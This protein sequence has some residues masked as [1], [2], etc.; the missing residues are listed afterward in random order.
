[1][2]IDS[3]KEAISW[4]TTEQELDR[5]VY[6]YGDLKEEKLGALFLYL[7]QKFSALAL[8]PGGG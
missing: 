3:Y 2:P 7:K 6:A 1:M 4:N 5:T 8:V